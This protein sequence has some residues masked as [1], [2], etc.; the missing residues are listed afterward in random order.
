[1]AMYK[2]DKEFCGRD[3]FMYR[4][5]NTAGCDTAIVKIEVSCGDTLQVFRGFS[6]NNDGKND[7]LVIR[8]IENFPD[9]EVIIMNRWGNQ[10]FSQKKY[11]NEDGWDGSWNNQYVPDGTY[12]YFIRLN[13][14][15]NQQF[16]GYIQLMR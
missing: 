12:F 9:N 14:S 15:K 16:T 2:P 11:R 8:G 3:S 7:K 5:C 1:M 4:I 6:P 13:D 10:V